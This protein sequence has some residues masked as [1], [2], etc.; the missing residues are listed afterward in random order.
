MYF[1]YILSNQS[2]TVLYIGVTNN[3]TR[4]LYEHEN[5]LVEGFTKKYKVHDLDYFEETESI[6]A[7]IEREKQLKRWRRSKKEVLIKRDNPDMKSL[8]SLVYK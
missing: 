5:H 2:R 8:N 3:L 4:R 7:A 6:E 1:V